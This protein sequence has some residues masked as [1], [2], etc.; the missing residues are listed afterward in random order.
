[1][2]DKEFF[3][4]LYQGWAKTTGASDAYW[5]P[6]ETVMPGQFTIAAVDEKGYRKPVAFGL[7]ENDAAFI[8]A[9]HGC[10]QDVVRYLLEVQDD[11]ERLE[12][13]RD[14]AQGE[15]FE[16]AVE[17]EELKYMLEEVGRS[18]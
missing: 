8:T 14:E 1:M 9:I 15:L 12:R 10:F 18:V 13:R 16:L 11:A 6:E 17:N 5:M 7:T 3:D 4:V 2:E